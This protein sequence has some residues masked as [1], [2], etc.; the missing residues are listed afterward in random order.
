MANVQQWVEQ[1]LSA[2]YGEEVRGSIAN[3]ILAMNEE[4]IEAHDVAIDSQTSAAN[5]A[6]AALTSSQNAANSESNAKTSEINAKKS[7]DNAKISESKALQS[8]NNAKNYDVSAAASSAAATAS[9]NAAALSE[10]NAK[11]SELNAANS[12]TQARTSADNAA[13][14]ALEAQ[15][16]STSAQ[17][18]S[19]NA[20]NSSIQAG[21]YAQDAKDAAAQASAI[22]GIGTATTTTPGIVRPDGTTIDINEFGTISVK[23][24]F[25][26]VDNTDPTEYREFDKIESNEVQYTFFN[27]LTAIAQNVRFLEKFRHWHENKEVI[28]KLSDKDGN[29]LYNEKEIIPEMITTKEQLESIVKTGTKVV[30]AFLIKTLIHESSQE[31]SEIHVHTDETDFKGLTVT[32]TTTNPETGEVETDTAVINENG[33][34]LITVY[35]VNTTYKVFVTIG[36]DEY[37]TNVDVPY[38]SVYPIDLVKES[39]TIAVSTLFSQLYGKNIRIS[40]GSTTIAT[41]ALSASGTFTQNVKELGTYT[42]ECIDSTIGSRVP[43]VNVTVTEFFKTFPVALEYNYATI[44]VTT[45]E[46]DLLGRDVTATIGGSTYRGTFPASLTSGV[47]TVDIDVYQKGTYTVSCTSAGGDTTE[48]TVEVLNFNTTNEVEL[49]LVNELIPIMTSNTTPSGVAKDSANSANAWKV[50]N[51]DKAVGDVLYGATAWYQYELPK[52]ETAK[53]FEF[54]QTIGGYR[55]GS[56]GVKIYG[57]NDG[58]TFTDL[59]GDFTIPNSV[60]DNTYDL[61]NSTAYKYYRFVTTPNNTYGGSTH[62]YSYFQLLKH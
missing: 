55:T 5:S 44:R 43:P 23:S 26:S 22:A 8:E 4:A 3:S 37:S 46:T 18:A 47:A 17:T 57:S 53:K 15:R 35:T 51:G 45:S 42:V 61:T 28:D 30:E 7:E 29:L 21:Q 14:S 13:Q 16:N 32:S 59:L 6:Q 34:A 50:F 60:L 54:K 19:N 38:Y 33:Y 41:G 31:H 27:K 36:T 24:V 52:A 49:T 11:T 12:N 25:A 39:A 10:L 9:K 40:K 1:I 62:V 48:E 56:S 2:R 58:T 20:A